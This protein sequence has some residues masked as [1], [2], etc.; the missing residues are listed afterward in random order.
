MHNLGRDPVVLLSTWL[1]HDKFAHPQQGIDPPLELAPEGSTVL[2]LPVACH[3]L[4]GSVVE[5]AYVILRV[6]WRG[7]PWRVFIRLRVT[8]DNSSIPQHM[9]ESVTVHPVGF[10]GHRGANP[11]ALGGPWNAAIAVHALSSSW[12]GCHSR[13][14]TGERDM[15]LGAK[16]RE[17]LTRMRGWRRRWG[18]DFEETTGMVSNSLNMELQDLLETL[19]RVQ[20]ECGT[21]P[22]YQELRQGLPEEWP[23]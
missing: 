9:C 22:E 13:D 15:A 19:E 8:V 5:N 20:R 2:E 21:D 14:T 18:G 1:P 7:Q 4:P 12:G 6:L 11:P 10:S 3:E 23:M 17:V 16:D